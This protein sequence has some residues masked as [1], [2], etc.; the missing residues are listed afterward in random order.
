MNKDEKFQK[1][2]VSF[3][4][5]YSP[6]KT[7]RGWVFNTIYGNL[8]MSL[9]KPEPRTKVFSVFMKFQDVDR[10]KKE[11]DCTPY[12]GKWNIHQHTSESALYCLN[13]ALNRVIPMITVIDLRNQKELTFNLKKILEVTN[14]GRDKDWIKYT[15]TD[16]LEGWMEWC[17]G[18]CYKIKTIFNHEMTE[19]FNNYYSELLYIP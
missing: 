15:E 3:I 2:V 18:N 9:Q 4:S 8:D 7:E 14:K 1:K 17:E 5:E 10:A 16:W 19:Q 6:E 13:E 11:V 12:S